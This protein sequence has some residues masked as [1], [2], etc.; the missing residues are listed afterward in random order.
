MSESQ[1]RPR[2]SKP[3]GERAPQRGQQEESAPQLSPSP[4]M[5]QDDALTLPPGALVALRKSGGL[6]FRSHTIVVYNDGRVET[7]RVGGGRAA[8]SGTGHTLGSAELAA[9]RRALD[10]IGFTQLPATIGQQR[11]DAFVYEIAALVGKATRTAEVADGQIP[12]TVAPLIRKL[13]QLLT[14]AS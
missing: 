5:P 7:S 1:D 8:T 2:R 14:S 13:N 12:A 3:A 6:I 11:P 4:S 9:L 10:Q